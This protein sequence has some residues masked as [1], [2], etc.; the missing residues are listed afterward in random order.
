MPEVQIRPAIAHDIPRLM[1]FDH[2]YTTE[3]VWQVQFHTE[4]E[5]ISLQLQRVRLPRHV[6]V[7]YPRPLETLPDD[8]TQRATLLVASIEESLVGYIGLVHAPMPATAWITDFAVDAPYR[9]QGIGKALLLAAQQWAA[10]QGYR[11]LAL[12]L[13]SKN[14]P[15]ISLANRMGYE[16]FGFGDRYYLNQDIALFFVRA[17]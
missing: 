2:S 1:A 4:A 3:H 14:H 5:V 7:G 17:V 13:Q 12:E 11:R 16:F 8:W 9:R 10:Q 15:A 6:R